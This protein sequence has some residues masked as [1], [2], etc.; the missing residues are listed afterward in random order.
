MFYC[1]ILFVLIVYVPVNNFSVMSGGSSQ[2][3]TLKQIKQDSQMNDTL[4]RANQLS[5]NG[6]ELTQW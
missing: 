6:V 4:R 3:K 5:Q 1:L 2:K